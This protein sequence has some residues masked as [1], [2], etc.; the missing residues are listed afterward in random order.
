[1]FQYKNFTFS[2]RFKINFF[3]F[4]VVK[5]NLMSIIYGERIINAKIFSAYG[6]NYI[7]CTPQLYNFHAF[8]IRH[9]IIFVISIFL[10]AQSDTEIDLISLSD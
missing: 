10:Y 6:V 2:Y 1:M 3:P 8:A 7:I 9:K 4:L 5:S